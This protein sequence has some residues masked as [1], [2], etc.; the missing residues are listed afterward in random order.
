MFQLLLFSIRLGPDTGLYSWRSEPCHLFTKI[1][2]NSIR[3]FFES[4]CRRLWA[5]VTRNWGSKCVNFVQLRWNHVLFNRQTMDTPY[6]RSAGPVR[7]GP[8]WLISTRGCLSQLPPDH[9]LQEANYEQSALQSP[10]F[11]NS[12][13][14]GRESRDP[15]Y[16]TFLCTPDEV[17]LSSPDQTRQPGGEWQDLRV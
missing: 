1:F 9:L 11:M 3:S 16:L 10:S 8:A 13:I 17:S 2:E 12:V 15:N 7:G 5:K 14:T 6:S 4:I